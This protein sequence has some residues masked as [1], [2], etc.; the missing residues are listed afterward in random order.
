MPV[1]GVC[2]WSHLEFWQGNGGR[3]EA[4]DDRE[5][6]SVRG[7]GELLEVLAAAEAGLASMPSASRTRG[8]RAQWAA[9]V[10]ASQRVVNAACAVQDDAIASLAAIEPAE[11]EDGTEVETHRAGGHVALDAAAIVSGVLAVSAVHAERR[12]RAAVRLAADGP[13]GTD[14]ETGLGGL[15]AVMRRGDLDAYRAGVVAE[16]LEEAPAQ[17]A[18]AVVATLGDH[19]VTDAAPQLRRRCRTVLSRISPDLV[20]ERAKRARERCALRRWAEEP[21]VDKWE[22]TF[23]SEDAARAWAAIDA[24]AHQLVADGTCPRI[25]RARSQALIDLVTGSAT[26]EAIVTLSVPAPT[27]DTVPAFPGDPCASLDEHRGD[28]SPVDTADPTLAAR[29]Q[30]AAA[31][32]AASSTLGNPAT[33]A[34]G[35]PDDLIE[36]SMG[37]RG[38]RVLVP[39]AFLDVVTK[40]VNAR[41]IP[42]TCHRDTGALLDHTTSTSYRPTERVAAL[43]RQRDGRCR[44]PGCQVNARFCD[45][46]HVRPWPTGPTAARNLIC[47]CRRHHRIKQRLGWRVRLH[48]DG[49][50]TWTDPT[51]PN[52]N[53]R[54]PSNA[55]A[56]LVLAGGRA[57]TL[58]KNPAAAA[59][60]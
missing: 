18:A 55:L 15:H 30:S 8:S 16:E 54:T 4:R 32:P 23:P 24:R 31:H 3:G 39:R 19:L 38:E 51:Q 12:V 49:T 52:P 41:V 43:V 56:T 36:V 46:D 35:S 21:G 1:P 26:I 28:P 22:G 6:G 50:L 20:R 34:S 45:L 14:T 29:D 27:Q 17:V 11:L 13:T 60:R 25:D 2:Q 7:A 37:T 53:H 42:R 5:A 10:S 33:V 9:V 57:P 58:R 44:F 59:D 40:G 48:P 47:L